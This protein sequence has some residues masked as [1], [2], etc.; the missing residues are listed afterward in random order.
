MVLGDFNLEVNNPTIRCMMND[1]NLSSLIQTPTCFKSASGRCIDL[2]LTNC[3]HGCFNSKT[4]ETGF[5]D[6][7][8]MVYT[9]LK[10]TFTRLPPRVARFRSYR[11]FSE[12]QFRTELGQKLSEC[13]SDRYED[14]EQLY[15]ETLNKYAPMKTISIRG[16]NKPHMTKV[17]RKAMNKRTRL[18]GIANKTHLDE[19]I[20]KYKKQRNLVVKM[21]K[22]S[23]IDFY[24]RLDPKDLENEKAFWRTFKPLMSDKCSNTTDKITLIED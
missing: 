3:K 21:N 18:K 15:L 11:S 8:H 4:F 5:S 10:T 17:L 7:H 6:F 13:Q 24:K 2:I 19:D 16:N 12:E 1:H 23:K 22:Q 14:I 9:N 20:R